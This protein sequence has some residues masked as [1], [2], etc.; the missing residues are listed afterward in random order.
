MVIT[1]MAAPGDLTNVQRSDIQSTQL[2]DLSVMPEGL[3]DTFDEQELLDLLAFLH[4]GGDPESSL[5]ARN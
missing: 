2:S 3:L 5:F 1:D 4:A